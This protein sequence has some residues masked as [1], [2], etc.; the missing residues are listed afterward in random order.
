MPMS[1]YNP[2]KENRMT[3][4]TEGRDDKLVQENGSKERRKGWEK[5]LR[6][7]DHRERRRRD[8]RTTRRQDDQK[9]NNYEGKENKTRERN[10]E[11]K[12]NWRPE[13]KNRRRKEVQMKQVTDC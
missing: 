1:V 10:I 6:V 5:K 7:K 13:A 11:E 3:W 4:R 9:E 2:S 12:E 8:E